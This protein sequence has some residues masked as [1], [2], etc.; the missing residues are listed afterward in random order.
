MN[1]SAAA[2]AVFKVQ[3]IA[4]EEWQS[5]WHRDTVCRL[6]VYPV[7]SQKLYVGSLVHFR[8]LQWASILNCRYQNVCKFVHCFEEG[9]GFAGGPKNFESLFS[10]RAAVGEGTS[11]IHT[12]KEALMVMQHS[13]SDPIKSI[14]GYVP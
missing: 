7:R 3:N 4:R 11:K 13:H 6:E 14:S 5:L 8:A 2:A 1:N 9:A 10:L 12:N